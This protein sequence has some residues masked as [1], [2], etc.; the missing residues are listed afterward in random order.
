GEAARAVAAE[1]RVLGVVAGSVEPALQV[2]ARAVVA[3][4][5]AELALVDAPQVRGGPAPRL[6]AR[7]RRQAVPE[8]V[9]RP[10]LVVE[11]LVAD[12]E[13][14]VDPEPRAVDLH[15]GQGGVL[16]ELPRLLGI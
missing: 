15:L 12:D 7:A 3:V 8:P 13:E 1:E 9:L 11:E 5:A 16:E 4:R 6:D 10:E 14:G 2:A